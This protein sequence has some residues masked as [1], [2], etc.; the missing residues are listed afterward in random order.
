M[1]CI[2]TCTEQRILWTISI[3]WKKTHIHLSPSFQTIQSTNGPG[4]VNFFSVSFKASTN[5]WSSSRMSFCSLNKKMIW[6][7][8]RMNNWFVVLRW[9]KNIYSCVHQDVVE[10]R[11]MPD[12]VPDRRFFLDILSEE[13]NVFLFESFCFWIFFSYGQSFKRT[14]WHQ[15]FQW[16]D[17]NMIISRW[18]R[19][20]RWNL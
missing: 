12:D 11:S 14:S 8:R 2:D 3:D 16:F 1:C 7:E 10:L 19:P 17:S 15:Y 18:I 9:V 6:I 5:A 4:S 13:E 20:S